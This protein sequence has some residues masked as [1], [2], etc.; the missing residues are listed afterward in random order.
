[1]L[2]LLTKGRPRVPFNAL[3][4]EY[5]APGIRVNAVT[6]GITKMPVHP[7]EYHETFGLP[8]PLGRMGGLNEVVGAAVYLEG[9]CLVAGEILHADGG[10]SSGR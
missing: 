6:P 4:N 10:Q 7:E 8:L 1:V 2:A 5:A 3:A 9:A